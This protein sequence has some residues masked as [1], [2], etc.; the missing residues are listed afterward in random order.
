MAEIAEV[1]RFW[2]AAAYYRYVF[3]LFFGP[4]LS[5]PRWAMNRALWGR[6]LKCIREAFIKCNSRVIG[7]HRRLWLYRH[8]F[9]CL[10]KW[11]HHTDEKNNADKGTGIMTIFHSAI[12]PKNIFPASNNDDTFSPPSITPKTLLQLPSQCQ[13]MDPMKWMECLGNNTLPEL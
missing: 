10:G 9:A 3:Q 8:G 7:N 5:K 1:N 6:S 13:L 2:H 11:M 12:T 4:I